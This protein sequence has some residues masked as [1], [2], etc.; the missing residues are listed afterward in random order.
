MVAI[1]SNHE[2]KKSLVPNCLLHNPMFLRNNE[3]LL[4]FNETTRKLTEITTGM[5]RPGAKS[6]GCHGNGRFL[7]YRNHYPSRRNLGKYLLFVWLCVCSKKTGTRRIMHLDK[8]YSIVRL[9]RL[10]TEDSSSRRIM[11]LVPVFILDT[12][13]QTNNE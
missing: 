5:C 13:N 12:H 6:C 2:M 3:H 9:E 1:Y 10:T 8:L 4:S 11:R 7:Y